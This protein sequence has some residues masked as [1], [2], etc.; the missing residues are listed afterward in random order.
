MRAAL[1]AA[2]LGAALLGAP[3]HA[4]GLAGDMAIGSPKARVE[5]I[6]YASVTCSHC[7]DFHRDVVPTLHKK[8]VDTG[9]VRWVF[10]EFP[11]QPIG[12]AVAGFQLAR[13]GKANPKTYFARVGKLFAEQDAIFA[14]LD[15]GQ[16]RAKF[17]ALAQAEGLSPAQL[18]ACFD[19]ESADPRL[20]ASVEAGQAA[21][22]TGTPTVFVNGEKVAF[23]DN[24]V[25]ALS[26][27]ID[28]ALAAPR[29]KR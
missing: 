18:Q 17:D 25:E 11:T 20:Q 10:R 7:R 29:K 13:C 24:T 28:A 14:A 16:G 19:D 22:V 1:V 26:K 23:E 3:A 8:Y 5:V 21:G 27:R 6:E 15:A 12:V 2:A 4:A 9:K